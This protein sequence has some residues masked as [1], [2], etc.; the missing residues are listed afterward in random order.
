MPNGCVRS[1]R[2]CKIMYS[3]HLPGTVNCQGARVGEMLGV[4]RGSSYKEV[5]FRYFDG[6]AKG[7]MWLQKYSISLDKMGLQ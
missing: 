2:Y 4:N 1:V 6:H 3:R 7:E 5:S